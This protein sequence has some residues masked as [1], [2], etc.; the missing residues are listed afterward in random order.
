MEKLSIKKTLKNDFILAISTCMALIGIVFLVLYKLFGLKFEKHISILNISV[1]EDF[2]YEVISIVIAALG[3]IL[4][5]LRYIKLKS[6]F[7]NAV[8]I[9]ATVTYAQFYGDRGQVTFSYNYSGTEYKHGVALA[10][11]K[12]TRGLNV[13]DQI[14]LLIDENNPKYFLIHSLY[15]E[16]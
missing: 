2:S 5:L 6:I 1:G 4:A 7:Q 16:E 15:C 13:G 9:N 12:E 8:L 3:I 11:T 14:A 10:R